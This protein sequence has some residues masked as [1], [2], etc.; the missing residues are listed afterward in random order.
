[1]SI[2]CRDA[3]P[4]TNRDTHFYTHRTT[5]QFISQQHRCS[6]LGWSPNQWNAKWADNP[7][8]L[9]IF[10]FIFTLEVVQRTYYI[11]IAQV[12]PAHPMFH[13]QLCGNQ[14]GSASLQWCVTVNQSAGRNS[15]FTSNKQ[16]LQRWPVATGRSTGVDSGRILRF[17]FGPGPGLKI[18]EKPD[19]HP[20]PL[21]TCRFRQ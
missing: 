7:K 18:C 14:R 13:N 3:R 9:R 21:Q 11:T 17:S 5:R 1:M 2:E 12:V 16:S 20:E 19:P 10:I 15:W 6:A 8:R 4:L